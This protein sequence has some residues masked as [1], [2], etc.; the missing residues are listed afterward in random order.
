MVRGT[1]M[2]V[3]GNSTPTWTL[4]VSLTNETPKPLTLYQHSEPWAG[5]YSTLLVAV[6]LDPMG[7]VIESNTPVDDPGPGTITIQPGQTRTG[8]ISLARHFPGFAEALADRDVIIF[9][10]YQM[11]PVDGDPLPRVAGHVLFA[12]TKPPAV[13]AR[14]I[15][16]GPATAE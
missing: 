12:K 10:S 16:K 7:T 1:R 9:W 6:K 2:V 4:E 13:R 3:Q 5:Y 15:G 8:Q 14:A 11:K